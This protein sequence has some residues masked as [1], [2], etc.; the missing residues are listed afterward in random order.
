MKLLLWNVEWFPS[1][2]S[3]EHISTVI[4]TEAPDIICLTESTNFLTF[5]WSK[6]ITS[7]ADYGYPNPGNRRK[8]WMWSRNGWS[9]VDYAENAGL[10]SGRFVSGITN[11]IRFVG[12]CVP[13]SNAHVSSGNRNRSRW[14][15][16]ITFL[17]ALAP[18]LNEYAASAH[19]VCVLG[20]FNQRI[21]SSDWNANQF[22]HLQSA[23][24]PNYQMHTADICDV[25]GE[26][27]ID[28][29]A[30]TKSLAFALERTLSRKTVAG[31]HISDHPGLLGKLV[32]EPNIAP[33][34]Q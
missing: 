4:A 28:H 25:D 8:V 11:G 3:R 29:V 22:E 24:H 23:F 12:I 6:V 34:F 9:G 10:P 32:R 5:D 17:N 2:I 7:T 27:L 26:P 33:K 1:K 16:H 31:K 20:D 19:P 13:W 30:T 21:P 15:D 18:I 14:E